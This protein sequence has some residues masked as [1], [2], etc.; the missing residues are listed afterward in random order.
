MGY[1][2]VAYFDRNLQIIA[3]HTYWDKKIWSKPRSDS[4][5][6]Y[7]SD[8]QYAKWC[9]KTSVI[10]SSHLKEW[11]IKCRFIEINA[12]VQSVQKY[13]EPNHAIRRLFKPFMYGTVSANNF[14]VE[15]LKKYS[16][17]HRV[18]GFEYKGFVNLMSDT[19]EAY[20][21]KILKK[22]FKNDANLRQ[23]YKELTGLLGIPISKFRYKRF[24]V[25]TLITHFVCTVTAYNKHLNEALSFE[26]LFAANLF[27]PKTANALQQF[28]GCAIRK[29]NDKSLNLNCAENDVL[30]FTEYI[31]VILCNG[32][33]ERNFD[34]ENEWVSAI[35]RDG[36]NAMK[37]AINLFKRT[38]WNLLNLE[39]QIN[40]KNKRRKMPYIACCVSRLQSSACL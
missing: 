33:K 14:F 8:W 3:I 18:F 20:K 12:F 2:A 10:V 11:T 30:A 24:N 40:E 29:N 1:G 5:S 17:Y 28:A 32:L 27:Y 38:H 22:K 13:L 37:K 21:F 31:L 34:L 26:G 39:K 16:L 9:W 36:S 7:L 15:L 6:Q 4:D 23:F 25:M 19:I 35:Y